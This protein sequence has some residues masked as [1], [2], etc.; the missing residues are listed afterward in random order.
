[1][2]NARTLPDLTAKQSKIGGGMCHKLI[3]MCV[4]K[5]H[6]TGGLFRG[7]MPIKCPDCNKEPK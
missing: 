4:H 5:G 2:N 3:F 6:R 7:N 1:V